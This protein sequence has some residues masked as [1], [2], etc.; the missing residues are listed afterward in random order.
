MNC[1]RKLCNE[2]ILTFTII[3]FDFC[4]FGGTTGTWWDQQAG[5]QR[6]NKQLNLLNDGLEKMG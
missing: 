1:V 5:E 4:I 2:E 3:I 6:Q